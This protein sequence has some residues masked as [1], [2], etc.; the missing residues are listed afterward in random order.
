MSVSSSTKGATC[1]VKYTAAT[2]GASAA[3]ASVT[4]DT[5]GC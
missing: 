1:Y 2:T 4:M 3:P 5:S